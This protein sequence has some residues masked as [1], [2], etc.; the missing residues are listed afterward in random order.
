VGCATS[1]NDEKTM[2]TETTESHMADGRPL[3]A[4]RPTPSASLRDFQS[5]IHKMYYAKD[6]ERGAEATFLWL[7]EEI[8]ELA[9][10]LRSG[11]K[12]ELGAEF[13][14]VLAW[15]TTIANVK[16]IDMTDEIEK[17]YGSGC[18][19]CGKFVCDCPDARKV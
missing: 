14:D 1:F 8:G 2:K 18:P 12:E 19:G 4:S 3:H 9:T 7:M 6:V 17:K 10:A 5:L 15:M 11:T 13:A 16:G